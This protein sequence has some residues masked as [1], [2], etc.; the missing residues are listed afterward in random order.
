VTEA[1]W[2]DAIAKDPYFAG[3]ETPYFIGQ[4]VVALATD[5]QVM[6]K[7]GKALATWH[8]AKEYGFH[9]ADGSQPH[10]ANFYAATR[11]DQTVK[12]S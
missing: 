10:W 9:D 7:S 2:R 11:E 1:H 12:S 8:L 3:S 4:A 5:P 6:E